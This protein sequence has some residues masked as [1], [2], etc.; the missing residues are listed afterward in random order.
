MN[1]RKNFL[2][3]FVL[4]FLF[5]SPLFLMSY[6][7]TKDFETAKNLDIFYS[8]F[9]E[10]S[11]SY[12]DEL[13]PGD[14]MSRTINEM[15]KTLDPYTNYIPESDVERYT[16]MSKG[17]YGGI[18][19]SVTKRDNAL[20]IT[21]IQKNSP[22]QAAGIILGDKIV[23]IDG[24]SIINTPYDEAMQLLQ[25]QMGTTMKL[26]IIR[27][28]ERKNF[29]IE[30]KNI[31]INS[32]PYYGMLTPEI[33]YI[34]LNEFSQLCSVDVLKAC[35]KLIGDDKAKGLVLDLRGNPGGLLIEAINIVN[36]FIPAGERI[37]FTKGQNKTENSKFSTQNEP[38][39]PDIPLVVLVNDRSASAAEIVSGALQDLDRA[40]VIGNQ[41]FGKGLVQTRKELAHNS[42]LKITTSKYYIPSGRCVKDG[43]G[44]IP[45]VTISKDSSSALLQDLLSKFVIFDFINT[46]YSQADTTSIKP[47]TYVFTDEDYQKFITFCERTDYTFHSESEKIL[48]SFAK[49]AD[50]EHL[51]ISSQVSVLQKN[52]DKQQADLFQ[53]DKAQISKEIESLVIR[54]LYAEEGQCKYLTRNDKFISEAKKYLTDSKLYNSVLKGK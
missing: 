41:T 48:A 34:K 45:D 28:G 20:M 15:L 33:G 44:I 9:S 25:G 3:I 5:S 7:D 52:I 17:E 32:V 13:A 42:L 21:D 50:K 53:N 30:R 38:F 24:H 37:V 40:V 43:G 27:N 26:G 54:N 11:N 10:I 47:E 14:L 23:E 12:V 22:A 49:A 6:D 36:I 16:I 31:K 4:V 51:D 8:L 29:S 39:A 1:M 46:Q 35:K 19:A 18:G 2:R